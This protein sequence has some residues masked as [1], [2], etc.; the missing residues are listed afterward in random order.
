MTFSTNEKVLAFDELSKRFYNR[1]FGT[2]TKS[3]VET[4][5]FHLYIEHLL[6]N[7]LPFDDY[8]MSKQL[9]IT[10]SKVRGL[11]LRKELQYPRKGFDWRSAFVSYIEHADYDADSQT[12]RMNIPDINVLTEL[13]YFMETNGWY[14]EYQ[15][16]PK[17]FRCKADFF[18][19]LCFKLSEEA[20]SLDTSAEKKLADIQKEIKADDTKSAIQKILDG[21]VQ[22]GLKELT[23]VA[24]KEILSSVIK[25]L[26]LGSLSVVAFDKL[27][28]LILKK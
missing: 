23:L 4:L 11:K 21:A 6:D 20:I 22:D 26:P 7:N 10:Q 27:W 2:M 5:F 25:S 24:S 14:D 9:G 13:R 1:N 18:A 17:L 12:V 16:N 19:E 15:L 3:D 28:Q 8:T